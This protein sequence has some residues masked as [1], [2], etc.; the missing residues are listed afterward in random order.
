MD[1]QESAAQNNQENILLLEGTN[2]FTTEPGQGKRKQE[3][4]CKCQ[5]V[6]SN[7][8]GWGILLSKP[9]K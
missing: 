8:Y 6:C 4:C 5:T 9:N 3:H 1:C 7:D 2:D